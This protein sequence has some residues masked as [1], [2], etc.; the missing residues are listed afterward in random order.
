MP[1]RRARQLPLPFRKKRGGYRD[2]AGRKPG[3]RPKTQH[4]ARPEHKRAH[5]VHVTMRSAFRPLRSQ[6]V[7]PT[8]QYAI[9]TANKHCGDVFRVVQFSVQADH[10]HLLVEADDKDAL[11]SGMRGLAVRIARAVNALVA[12]R[13]QVWADR[14]HGRALTS[15]RAA[16][17]ALTYVLAN[18]RKHHPRARAIVDPFSSALYFV[19]FREYGG[20][21]PIE[22][23]S[24]LA[25]RVMRPPGELPVTRPSTW[26]LRVGWRKTGGDL[27]AYDAP[28]GHF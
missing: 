11:S 12:R 4:R 10:V 15:P 28:K 2:G 1:R 13:G 16:R 22:A 24:P 21:A 25:R 17:H 19:G 26:L 6:F 8:V 7:F 3:V 18:F 27:S 5:P 14:W 9:A 23:S 20:R